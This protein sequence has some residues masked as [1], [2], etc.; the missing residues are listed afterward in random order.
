MNKHKNNRCEVKYLC[1]LGLALLCVLLVFLSYFAFQKPS[2][3]K[4]SPDG[5]SCFMLFADNELALCITRDLSCYPYFELLLASK[6]HHQK[7]VLR[8]ISGN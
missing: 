8:F 2:S 4:W 3:K 7:K 1:F 5:I 6:S